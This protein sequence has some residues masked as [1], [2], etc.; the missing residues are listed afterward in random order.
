MM[1]VWMAA[2]LAFAWVLATTLVG[3]SA[4]TAKYRSTAPDPR[5]RQVPAEIQ[6]G[7]F[8][9]PARFRE[10]LVRFL[11]AGERDPY[12]KVKLLH[13]WIADNIAYDVKSY[14]STEK[15]ESNAADALQRRVAVCHGYGSLMEEMCELAGITCRTI[16][17]YGRGY[18]F[19]SGEV[20]SSDRENHVWNAVSLDGR[21]HL[22]DVT[23]DAGHVEG[24]EFQKQYSTTYLF[25]EPRHFV[26]THLPN[27]PKWQLLARP[28]T[29]EEFDQLPHL[30][31][32]FFDNGLLLQ[33]RL[34]RVTPAGSSVQFS[35]GLTQDV[36][37]M[38]TLCTSDDQEVPQRTFVQREG[39][40]CPIYV[41]FPRAGRYRVK[42]YC[43]PPGA[44]D[45]YKQAADLDFQASE[46]TPKGFPETYAAFDRMSGYL[47]SPLYL[48]LATDKP[49]AFKVRL[50]GAHDVSL[51]IGENPWLALDPVPGQ[52]DVYQLNTPVPAGERVRLNAKRS[53]AD[54]SYK[55][56]IDFSGEKS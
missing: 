43:R 20:G 30:R 52:K 27:E 9:D 1:R 19:A 31:G 8:Q 18:L 6:N 4:E 11:V 17:G 23:W 34:A 44:T 24:R 36:E 10:P 54:E 48:P 7:V 22:V 38:A 55:I 42:L 41:T 29:T 39:Q 13:D 35:I 2:G 28:L 45:T 12:R 40:R 49:V 5:V 16:S 56:V 15:H 53:P 21:W 26:Y 3:V 51:A 37:L 47:Y 46:G 33:T 50:S 14:F 25:M 32:R